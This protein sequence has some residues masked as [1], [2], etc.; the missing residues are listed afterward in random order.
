VHLL[1]L[2]PQVLL[3]LTVQVCE[4]VVHHLVQLQRA[5]VVHGDQREVHG[6]RLTVQG[7]HNHL[8]LNVGVCCESKE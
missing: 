1:C 3:H 7:V 5:L 4:D 6:E 8:G 2:V